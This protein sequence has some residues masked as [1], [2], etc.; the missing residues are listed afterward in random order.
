MVGVRRAR[1]Q[2]VCFEAR[3]CLAEAYR[4]NGIAERIEHKES[5]HQTIA[6]ALNGQW[7]VGLVLDKQNTRDLKVA[8]RADGR[9]KSE[10]HFNGSVFRPIGVACLTNRVSNS[11]QQ[12]G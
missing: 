9:R 6:R 11:R 7:C 1:R 2:T 5:K 3:V 4:G 8:V 12:G 10:L